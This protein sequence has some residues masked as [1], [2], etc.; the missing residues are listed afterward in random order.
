MEHKQRTAHMNLRD[1]ILSFRSRSLPFF[2][3]MNWYDMIRN[4]IMWWWWTRF[5]PTTQP[6]NQATNSSQQVMTINHVHLPAAE[7][8]FGFGSGFGFGFGLARMALA[9]AVEGVFVLLRR[10]SRM[11]LMLFLSVTHNY[12][13][14][15]VCL[16]LYGALLFYCYDMF[17]ATVLAWGA[18]WLDGLRS[19]LIFTQIRVSSVYHLL[20]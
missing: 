18:R 17:L 16:F 19:F 3:C 20:S 4:G 7:L 14:R 12:C 13:V 2:Y 11:L 1:S 9:T 6:I 10:Y 5:Q 15:S 8:T